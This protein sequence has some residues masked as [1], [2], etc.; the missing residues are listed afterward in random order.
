MDFANKHQD[1]PS[2]PQA[3]IQYQVD[4]DDIK[5]DQITSYFKR[6]DSEFAYNRTRPS[7]GVLDFNSQYSSPSSGVIYADPNLKPQS[8][9][10]KRSTHEIYKSLYDR[11]VANGK[12]SGFRY[13]NDD[14]ELKKYGAKLNG[15]DRYGWYNVNSYVNNDGGYFIGNNYETLPFPTR[16]DAQTFK[17]KNGK[18]TL[19]QEGDSWVNDLPSAGGKQFVGDQL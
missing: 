6:G 14:S 15:I 16:F 7:Q 17:L 2:G 10:D 13:A 18:W 11:A 1:F 5:N 9:N 4:F 19:T 12:A 3:P 8:Q